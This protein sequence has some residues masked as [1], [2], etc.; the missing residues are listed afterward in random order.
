MIYL[1][2]E[3]VKLAIELLDDRE[4]RPSWPLHVQEAEFKPKEG[5]GNEK[6]KKGAPVNKMNKKASEARQLQFRG[7]LFLFSFSFCFFHSPHTRRALSWTDKKA[8]GPTVVVLKN[9]F[10]AEEEEVALRSL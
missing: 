6:K 9:M 7:N 8:K 1:R 3:S 5:G 10:T 4:L 2:P